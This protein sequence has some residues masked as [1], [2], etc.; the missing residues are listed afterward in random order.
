MAYT[1]TPQLWPHIAAALAVWGAGAFGSPL[2]FP[3]L[4]WD[5]AGPDTLLAAILVG[6]TSFYAAETSQLRQAALTQTKIAES[7]HRLRCPHLV[8]HIAS[9]SGVLALGIVNVGGTAALD[10]VVDVQFFDPED[11]SDDSP[12]QRSPML[13]AL[14]P[15][16]RVYF[17]H[18]RG[19]HAEADQERSKLGRIA[20]RVSYRTT[21]DDT[22]EIAQSELDAE[23]YMT[24]LRAAHLTECPRA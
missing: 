12:A 16:D 11:R 14:L 6:V 8:A 2:L 5:P 22:V 18:P 1:R 15:N 3:G 23:Q 21:T 13:G 19:L 20:Y 4:D 24:E 10:V 17:D 7:E 9:R